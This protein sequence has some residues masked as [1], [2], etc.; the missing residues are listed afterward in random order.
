MSTISKTVSTEDGDK[1]YIYFTNEKQ[2]GQIMVGTDDPKQEIILLHEVKKDNPLEEV[3]QLTQHQSTE[4]SNNIE[5]TNQVTSTEVSHTQTT[6][7]QE[8]NNTL[9][10]INTQITPLPNP[11]ESIVDQQ[12]MSPITQTSPIVEMDTLATSGL[13]STFL[14]N[15]SSTF[16]VDSTGNVDIQGD[17]WVEGYSTFQN[18]VAVSGGVLVQDTLYTSTIQSTTPMLITTP[19]LQIYKLIEGSEHVLDVSGNS[20][21]NGSIT[22]TNITDN[23]TTQLQ[24]V[25]IQESVY[26]PEIHV[27]LLWIHSL[28]IMKQNPTYIT[29]IRG[30]ITQNNLFSIVD[31]NTNEVI[32][33]LPRTITH[34]YIPFQS[35]SIYMCS[36]TITPIVLTYMKGIELQPGDYDMYLLDNFISI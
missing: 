22:A 24:K 17:V 35:G 30:T 9:D 7:I 32:S 34:I 19:L 26:T 16:H 36:S 11:S 31:K 23:G 20:T 5:V 2:D 6:P 14:S 13:Y 25:L 21:F 12:N 18:G 8:Q 4:P 28:G 15:S 3:F 29:S 10:S 1:K 33:V 27:G